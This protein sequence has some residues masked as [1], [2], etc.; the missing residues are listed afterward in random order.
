MWIELEKPQ[1]WDAKPRSGPDVGTDPVNGTS[2]PCGE[3]RQNSSTGLSTG[4]AGLPSHLYLGDHAK[5]WLYLGVWICRYFK[6]G[7]DLSTGKGIYP[8]IIAGYPQFSSLDK[9][10]RDQT[11]PKYGQ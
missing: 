6:S 11:C 3:N 2:S 1:M 10:A 4:R 8:Q 9:G 5:G 7:F